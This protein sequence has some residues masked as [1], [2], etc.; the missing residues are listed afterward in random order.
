MKDK[1]QNADRRKFLR[2]GFKA[3]GAFL[4][5]LSKID[6]LESEKVKIMTADGKVVEVDKRFLQKKKSK[7]TKNKDIL[8]WM[9]N[10]SKK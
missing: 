3:G 4:A 1:K 6:P 10:P 8:D 2:E 7:P 9:N 5:G